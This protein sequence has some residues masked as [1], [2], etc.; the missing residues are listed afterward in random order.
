[1]SIHVNSCIYKI[2][3]TSIKV[4]IQ[5]QKIMF[6]QLNTNFKKKIKRVKCNIFS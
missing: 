4:G 3:F 2:M 6:N 5:K 1:M